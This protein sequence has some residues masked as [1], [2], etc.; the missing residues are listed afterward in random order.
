MKKIN[1]KRILCAVLVAVT[2]I[3]GY[4]PGAVMAAGTVNLGTDD[5]I[6][7]VNFEANVPTAGDKLVIVFDIKGKQSD[8]KLEKI[9][10]NADGSSSIE[11]NRDAY[12]QYDLANE[13]GS[14]ENEVADFHLSYTIIDNISTG[15]HEIAF[16]IIYKKLD[17][18]GNYQTYKTTER[19]NVAIN[20]KSEPDPEPVIEAA[21]TDVN[22]Q[23]ATAPT[24]TYSQPCGI[25][26]V[27]KANG[28]CSITN[29]APVIA[30]GFPFE[31][32]GDAYKHIVATK[33]KELQCDF[34][35]MVRSDVT[36]G[37]QPVTFA[38]T[39]EKEGKTFTANKTINVKLEGKK[40]EEPKPEVVPESADNDVLLVVDKTISAKYSEACK[41]KFTVKS[42]NCM[43]TNVAPVI[44][45]TFPF[46]TAGDAY[47]NIVSKGAKTLNC[48]YNFVARSDVA[49]GYMPV[50]F[51][52]TYVKDGKNFTANK[53]INVKFTGKKEAGP[54]TP[55]ADVK[56]STPRL[57]VIGCETDL[58]QIYPND[59]FTLKVRLKNTAKYDVQNIKVT[60]ASDDK[61]FVSTNGANS[62]YID[63]VGSGEEAEL[64][65]ELLAGP[66]LEAKA[67]S[68]SIKTEYEDKKVNQYTSEDILSINMS[69][70]ADFKL[71]DMSVP[72][73][74][75]VGGQSTL[76]FS[77][78]NTGAA[79]LYN[80]KVRC[81]G[82]DFS[83]EE[84]YVGNVATGSTGY[85]TVLLTGENVT[86]DEGACKIYVTYE[87]NRGNL[88]EYTEDTNLYVMDMPVQE[89]FPGGDIIEEPVQK[90]VIWPYIVGGVA[91]VAIVAFFI[92]RGKKKRK[93]AEEELMEDDV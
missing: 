67:Y 79:T 78:S 23:V 72:F 27:A 58:K 56:E 26:F 46:E 18:D 89:E 28:N 21:D 8:Y 45:E 92:I 43:I 77:V 2:I 1:L 32:T 66:G 40:T 90:K 63:K 37:Y 25:S 54:V 22:I 80:V 87:D 15:Y 34:N 11:K 69:L 85:A 10:L 75:F 5:D 50:T 47:K 84:Y 74:L 48:S 59:V 41:V 44:S 93:I 4:R 61:S 53:S 68:L 30:D 29:V 3:G 31:T 65:F 60:L 9:Y 55:P 73:D 64:S 42:A 86:N 17:D 35:F 51:A 19:H 82:N 70:K 36:T 20:Q 7:L 83:A 12:K 14:Y 16:D 6:E 49:T 13:S 81:E 38:I 57:M 24:G 71:T 52:V 33:V 91:V 76:S 62:A 88:Y 39:Y